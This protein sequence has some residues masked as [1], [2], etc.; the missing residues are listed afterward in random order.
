MAV[1]LGPVAP[2]PLGFVGSPPTTAARLLDS[3]LLRAAAADNPGAD[4]VVLMSD[5]L[6]SFAVD[7]ADPAFT[8]HRVETKDYHDHGWLW[9]G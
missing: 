6:H 9:I 7:P 1:T 5:A 4:V 8:R 2:G 3:D